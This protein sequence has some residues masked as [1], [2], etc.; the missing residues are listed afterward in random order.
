M[1]TLTFFALVGIFS[2]CA[3]HQPTTAARLEQRAFDEFQNYVVI[4][5]FKYHRN[6]IRFAS[7]AHNDLSLNA[8]L[9]L[10]P[11]RN[12]YYVY[13][14]S[15][16]DR[17]QA[18]SEARRLRVESEFTDTWVYSGALGKDAVLRNDGK[19]S[20]VDINPMTSQDMNNVSSDDH[21]SE[22]SSS[23]IAQGVTADVGIQEKDGANTISAITVNKNQSSPSQ[24]SLDDGKEGKRFMFKLF[25]SVDNAPVEGDVNVID[26][27]RSRMMASYKGNTVVKVTDPASKSDNVSLV[28]EVFGYRK[29][30]RDL[31]YGNP[32]GEGV[33]KDDQGAVVV[34]FELVR[35]QRGDIAVMY[36]VYFFKDASVMRPESRYEVNSLLEMLNEN[37]KYK[38]KIHGHTNGGAHGKIISMN[39][40]SK[41]FF[42]LN[43][44]REGFGSAKQLSEERAALIRDYLISNG[45]DPARMQIKAWGGKRAIHDKHSTRAQENV[46]VEVEIL[47]N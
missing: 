33:V 11:V 41:N 20:G 13:V 39:K 21:L 43:D 38:I 37:P 12:L 7:H 31:N 27:D 16:N 24:A 34:P 40:D 25:R 35:L 30:Q 23:Q 3:T 2:I 19:I 10:N 22:S 5:A 1:K 6:A 45:I 9:E 8:H 44:T 18:I 26:A 15:T 36:N 47:E 28:C 42:S 46:R 29:I 17:T 14:L 32:E 4:G